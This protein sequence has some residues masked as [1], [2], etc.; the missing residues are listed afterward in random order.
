MIRHFF[1]LIYRSFKRFKTIFFINLAGLSTGLACT[2]LI[3]LWVMDEWS[4]DRYHEKGD[5]LFQIMENEKTNEGL[6]T[7]GH[8]HPFLAEVLAAEMPEVEH[9]VTVTPPYF[10][11]DFNVT[12]NDKNVQGMGKY[13][14]DDF[15]NMFSYE[16][17]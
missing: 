2:L 14:D 12:A 16:L 3:C 8:T 7:S 10:F 13:V 5:R 11:P 4:F 6:E 17:L 1:L 15:F 9:A